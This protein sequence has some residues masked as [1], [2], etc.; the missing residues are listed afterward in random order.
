MR[1]GQHDAPKLS[2]E[3]MKQLA[4]SGDVSDFES[5]K[6][7]IYLRESAEL[8]NISKKLQKTVMEEG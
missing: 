3:E 1:T 5:L 8:K 4:T 6:K 2:K 7:L